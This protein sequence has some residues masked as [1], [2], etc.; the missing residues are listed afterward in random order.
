MARISDHDTG[1][2][3]REG[4][5]PK[6]KHPPKQLRDDA[7]ISSAEAASLFAEFAKL[8]AIVLA[9][10]GGPDSTALM[11]LMS[12][13]LSRRK[14]APRLTAVTVDHGLRRESRAE[15]AAVRKLAEALGI[16]HATLRWSGDKPSSGLPA[17][18]R[19]ARYA[20]LAEAARKAG[21]NC[22]LTAH[23]SDDQ[24]ETFMMRLSRGSGLAGLASMSRYAFRDDLVIVRPFLNVPKARLI[25]T[26]ARAK[27]TFADDPTN[28][29]TTFTRPRWRQ[30]LP[31]LAEEGIDQRN[32][33][34]LVLRL[35]R[36]N[37]ALDAVVARAE[38][39]LVQRDDKRQSLDVTAF[40]SFP[41]EIRV[42]LLHRA[43]DRAGHEGPAELGKVESLL[44]Q[45][46]DALSVRP[47]R[48]FR[49]TLAGALVGMGRG[50]IV[51]EP[52]P[53][54]RTGRTRS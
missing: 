47:A 51:I 5:A 21:T 13:W 49:R 50:T 26:L 39:A 53:P 23:T 31:Q 24:V 29:D 7:P 28:R 6:S 45:L 25:A 40:L 19:E 54:R 2:M 34:R 52:A 48:A 1:G 46:V 38:R 11:W 35:A 44:D 4:A 20:L 17:A 15:A 22:V 36:A 9:V 33:E 8:P 18:A 41:A 37:A 12:R 14:T 30:L 32:I 27:I 43:I 42:R 10:S 3:P 16:E